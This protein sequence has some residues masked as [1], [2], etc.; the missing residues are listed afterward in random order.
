MGLARTSQKWRSVSLVRGTAT[1]IEEKR[2][3]IRQLANL[4]A[5][6]ETRYGY[7][8]TDDEL[9][10]CCFG[11]KAPVAGG[12]AAVGPARADVDG[13]DFF[14]GSQKKDDDD[15]WTNW[16]VAI[17]AV[18]WST[19]LSAGAGYGGG[20]RHV[21]T[22]ELALWWLCMLALSDGH[23]QLVE[24]KDIVPIDSWDT[25][26]A[27]DDCGWVRRHKYSLAEEPTNP[28]PPP[29]YEEPVLGNTTAFAINIGISG[30]NWQGLVD[31]ATID[32]TSLGWP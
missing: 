16:S 5:R 29:V 20:A 10:V 3:P 18:P 12:G 7:I 21:L 8:Q 26:H 30:G 1:G 19:E 25:V 28:P 6:S 27:G 17:M 24:T 2:W 4:C 13:A 22:T 23:R 11:A 15:E 31:P 32:L 9:V 14:G